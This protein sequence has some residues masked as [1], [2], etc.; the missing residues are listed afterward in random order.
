MALYCRIK[1]V[2]NSLMG[3]FDY[4][5]HYSLS[6]QPSTPEKRLISLANGQFSCA[7]RITHGGGY[8]ATPTGTHQL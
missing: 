3:A 4:S 8:F 1:G 2:E 7:S 6:C 5:D